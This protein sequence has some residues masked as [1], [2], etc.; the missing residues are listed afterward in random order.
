VLAADWAGVQGL[1]VASV[2]D[3]GEDATGEAYVAAMQEGIAD[4]STTAC[5]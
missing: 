1:H 3:L 2:K 4:R 5:C